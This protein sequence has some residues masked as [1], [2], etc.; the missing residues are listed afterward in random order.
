MQTLER[1]NSVKEVNMEENNK[2]EFIRNYLNSQSYQKDFVN[3][4]VNMLD[5]YGV[6]I[7]NL[8]GIGEQ[9]DMNKA[10]KKMVNSDNVAN[11][12][13]DANANAGGT[14]AISIMHEIAKPMVLLQ[15][16]YRLWKWLKKNRS[17]E[18]ANKFVE[19]QITGAFYVNDM[20]YNSYPMPYCYN[21]SCLS[22]ASLGLVGIDDKNNTQPPKYLRSYFDIMEAYLLIA[23]NSTAG[24]SSCANLLVVASVFVKKM[25]DSGYKDSHVQLNSEEDC[26]QYFK[27]ELT[28]FIYK[29]N[30]PCRGNQSLFTN[31][32]IFDK[33]FLSTIIPETQLI[34]DDEIYGTD[35][36]TVQKCQEIF[37]DVM[38]EEAKRVVHTFPVTTA[39]FSIKK[40]EKTGKNEILDK[41]FL[42]FIC[43][44]N[45]ERGFIN[46]YAGDTAT[47]SSCC[48]TKDTKVLAKSSNLGVIFDTFEN[49]E[50]MKPYDDYKKN[51]TVF[52]NGSWVRGNLVKLPRGNKKL[53][54]IVTTNNKTICVTED[55]INVTFDGDK[56]TR[57]LT[58]DDYLAFN[59]R[60]LDTFP[61]KDM[62]LT[63]E[64]GY[65]V[66]LYL[67]DGSKYKRKDSESYEVTFS[68]NENNQ[69]DLE[70]LRK[71]LTQWNIDK[72]IHIY[73]QHNT[74]LTK[75]YSKELYEILDNYIDGD[76]AYEKELNMQVLLQS[77]G[78]RKG[79]I[80]GWYASDGGNS[81]RIYTTSEKLIPQAE[82]LFTSIGLNTV[83][84]VSDKTGEGMVCIRESQSN[85][86]Y[87]LYCIR[88][89][90][91]KN[92]RSMG[93][94]YK[95]RNNTEYFKIQSIK[96]IDY[97]DEYVYCFE[98]KNEDEP[99]F[100]LP[101]G[102]ITHNC[103]LRSDKNNTFFN[104]FGG[105]SDSIGSL[106]VVCINLP[107]LAYKYKDNF[108]KFKE[109]LFN[110][111]LLA[112]EV[113]YAK[114]CMLK[115]SIAKGH[116]PL[117][118]HGYMDLTKQFSTTGFIGLYEC[119][120]T[121]GHD[122][123][124]PE[125]LKIATETLSVLEKANDAV[126][127]KYKIPCNLEGIPGENTCHKL[128]LKDKILGYN[129][130]CNL[131][132]NQF[133]PLNKRCNLLDRITLSSIM[134]QYCSGGSIMAI[135]VDGEINKDLMKEIA[136]S[137]I[138][139][140]VKYFSFNYEINQC[141][142]CNT[143]FVGK[144]TECP[145]CKS[146]NLDRY[147]RVV[148]FLTK[149][150]SWSKA[151]QDEDRQ[152]YTFN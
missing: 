150:S 85:R 24:A 149:K 144:K 57:S 147:M 80:D 72:E 53:Y 71:A 43:K 89:Y 66:G 6:E 37:L 84:D 34:I 41:D 25:I 1:E 81:L 75:V 132:S 142:D 73:W 54:E 108:E 70:I 115:N 116:L 121:L 123:V 82:A 13:I 87:P 152:F 40:D 78:F 44:K 8:N 35:I 30:Q 60:K 83:V 109:E 130:D 88:W 59:T 47:L 33:N 51:F 67:G 11:G 101:N 106:G 46:M 98:M 95:V 110:L 29:L 31:V 117:Y 129:K 38:N 94:I 74:M 22:I 86:N 137:I 36:E 143:I 113:N 90:D 133:I 151:R 91:M 10:I 62:K 79:I 140:G 119:C 15:S 76:Y 9:L 49:I 141:K 18:V 99:Y 100:T 93:D 42:E 139:S 4:M 124:T 56:D 127:E 27:E 55:H 118:S 2:K 58:T 148:G 39:C 61:E 7:F 114:R 96:E 45:E 64:Q 112:Q 128:A 50:N 125:G 28:A 145:E 19:A 138:E 120:E 63:Y 3:F 14:S 5:K 12:T 136:T 32:S 92:K 16:Y 102:I 48:F 20:H 77:I 122:I 17:I 21:H 26:W 97:A 107:Q 52:H 105:A 103:R 111:T 23:G 135:T 69:P 65:V 131:Y 104:S 146:E 68:L 134:D 126:S